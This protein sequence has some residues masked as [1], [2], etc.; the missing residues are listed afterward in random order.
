MSD[1]TPLLVTVALSGKEAQAVE[2]LHRTGLW[3]ADLGETVRALALIEVRSQQIAEEMRRTYMQASLAASFAQ[4][5]LRP[6]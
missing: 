5:N 1:P 2:K 4:S 6:R 3:G